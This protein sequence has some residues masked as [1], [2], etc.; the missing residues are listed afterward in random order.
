MFP[1]L[2]TVCPA[3]FFGQSERELSLRA[4]ESLKDGNE[5]WTY[6]DFVNLAISC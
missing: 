6:R 2:S 4:K 1:R 3:A 5:L